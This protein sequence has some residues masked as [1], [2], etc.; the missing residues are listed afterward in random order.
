MSWFDRWRGIHWDPPGN[1]I[2]LGL[3]LAVLVV[4]Y[5]VYVYRRTEAP[6]RPGFRTL[7]AGLRAATLLL[8]VAILCRPVLS[9]ALP[10]GASRGVLVL[11]DRSES[12]TLPGREPDRTRDDELRQALDGVTRELGSAYP[13]AL[14]GFDRKL[15]PVVPELPPGLPDGEGT[16]L[17]AALER[18][19]AEG[20]P[21]GRPGALV[22]VSDGAQTEGPDPVPLARRLGVPVE[23]VALGSAEPV[24]DLALTRVRVNR[25]AFAGER[26][27]LE[28]VLRLQGLDSTS[29]RVHLYDVTDGE[30]EIAAAT[31]HLDADGAEQRVGLSFTPEATGLRFLEVRV[32]PLPGEATPDNNRRLVAVR[33]REEKTGVLILTGRM[34]WDHTF[35]RR[36]LE[37]DSTLTVA[38]GYW[39]G[40][41]F[42][43]DTGGTLPALNAA[44]LRTT[45]VLVLDHVTPAQLPAATQSTL[46]GFVRAGG[47]LLMITGALPGIMAQWEHAKLGD[48]LPVRAAAT[49]NLVDP[50]QVHLTAAGRRHAVFDAS[51][52]GAAPVDAWADLPPV[53]PAPDLGSLKAGAEA[54]MTGGPGADP[55]V[56]W[57][58]V[59]Q[60]SVFLIGAGG[61]WKWGFMSASLGPGGSVLPPWWRR[62]AHW[63]ARP[64]LETHLD[65]HPEDDVVSRGEAVTFV[66]RVT[67]ESFD[68]IP[69][70]DV[71]VKVLPAAGSSTEPRTVK[72]NGAEGFYSGVVDDLPPG[73]YRFEG[74]AVNQGKDLGSADGVVAVDSL[75][76]EMERL[77]ADH[78]ILE[79][80]AAASGGRTWS[81][82]SLAGMR[83]V[84]STLEANEEER[85]QLALWD[86]PLAFVLVVLLASVEWY[87]RRRR[88]LV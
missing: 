46:A 44:G 10:G 29:V 34:T 20:G 28:A 60:G 61:V 70:V 8:L 69:G 24:P 3:V 68:P 30:A 19:M 86:H 51:V 14:R 88:G 41:R 23:T 67:D 6:L 49:G 4:A 64:G 35:L 73:R 15:G 72:L 22:L 17:A 47:G 78:E 36:A 33:V 5:A 53:E 18:G 25:E 2:W 80:I 82:D 31:A 83:R 65:I 66:A 9:L 13:L 32:P 39:R 84:F 50:I 52:P 26:T 42:V 11:L 56:S 27:P 85:V 59:G 81:P 21:A 74:R 63:L 40:G 54:L 87:L 57:N 43:G 45:R 7:L 75:G 38:S 77:E 1:G 71:T 16:D 12:L 58:R 37:A 79:R 62:V 48:L 55:V 76:T